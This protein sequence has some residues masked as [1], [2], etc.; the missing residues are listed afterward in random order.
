MMTKTNNYPQ[1]PSYVNWNQE[2]DL[3][4]FWDDVPGE[5]GYRIGLFAERADEPFY[6]H[7]DTETETGNWHT[8]AEHQHPVLC[9]N[10]GKEAID[11]YLEK[12]WI[13]IWKRLEKGGFND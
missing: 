10:S 1:I 3:L 5:H 2:Y 13:A 9:Y 8:I 11:A 7:V 4:S 6:I 12:A